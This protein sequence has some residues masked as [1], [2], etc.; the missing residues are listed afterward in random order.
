MK[1]LDVN[2]VIGA[3]ERTAKA[4]CSILLIALPTTAVLASQSLQ[5][6]NVAFTHM[7]CEYLQNPLGIDVIAPRLSWEESSS[8]SSYM[9]SA[10]RIIVSS[11]P[12]AAARGIGDLWD[13][14]KVDSGRSTLIK[15]N[16]ARLSSREHCW[17]S[18]EAW[19]GFGKKSAWSKPAAFSLGLLS[20]QDWSGSWIG[21]DA[22]SPQTDLSA[23]SGAQWIW[24]PDAGQPS[25]AAPIASRY[26]RFTMNI[27]QGKVIKRAQFVGTADNEFTLFVNGRTAG[28]N[29]NWYQVQTI[30][31]TRLLHPGVNELALKADN[32]GDAPNP[33]GLIG[34]LKVDYTDG[35]QTIIQTG[36]GWKSSQTADSG[37]TSSAYD[38]SGWQPALI[39]G[40]NGMQPWG[41]LKTAALSFHPP[42]PARYLR[43]EFTV[44]KKVVSATAYVCGLGFFQLTVNGKPVSDHIFD[45]VLSDYRRA[46]YYVTFD[47]ADLLRGGKN[48]VGVILGNGRYYAPR[49]LD[50]YPAISTS[51]PRLLMQ[52]EITYADGSMQRVVSDGNWQVTSDGPI[53]AN[54][55]YDAEIYDAR[56]A[57][58]GWDR[59]GY[60]PAIDNWSQADIMSSPGGVLCS[61]MM[62][63]MRIT[64]IIHPVGISSPKTG[65][66]IV[67]MGQS[68]Y[69]TVRL[70]AH[71]SRGASVSMQSAYTLLPSGFLKT[72]DNRSALATDI[73]TF[74]GAG[75]ETWNPIFKGQGYRRVQ[76]T[77]FPGKPKTSNFEGLEEHTDCRQVGSFSCSND[78]VNKIHGAMRTGM[79]MFL[80]STPIDPDRDERQAWMG[81]P[82]KDSESEAYN[83]DV[84][85]FYTK[86]MDDVRRS[87]RPDGTIPDVAM[88]WVFGA[89]V[90]WPSVFTIIPDW[91]TGFYADNTLEQ[92]NYDAMKQWVLAMQRLHVRPAG[93]LEA[94]S[95]GDW[96]DAYTIGGKV[97][98]YGETPRDLISTAYQ[99][100][101]IR[102]VQHAAERMSLTEDADTF[103]Q[104][105]DTM[106]DAFLKKFY[107]P[108][109]NSYE[110]GTQCSYVLPLAFGL[111]PEDPAQ[112]AAI[113][114]NLVHDIMVTHNGHLTVGLIG[115]QWL[116][117]VLTAC[118]RSDVS[119]TILTQT[120]RPSWGY[121][122]KRGSTTIWERWDYDTRDPGMNSEAL[123]IQAGNVDAWLYQTLGGINFD[124][125]KPG[126]SHIF[127]RPQMVGDLKWVKCSFDS[128]HGLIIS[129]WTRT[130]QTA[131]MSITIPSNTSATVTTPDGKIRELMS[132]S[133]KLISNVN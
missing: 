63:P 43:R 107:D 87:Q 46:D 60:S 102:I 88:Y 97:S 39:L 105:G 51:S 91:F 62:E 73:Y 84:A 89:G 48:A 13:S 35:S 11:S 20:K 71:A 21:K 68:F 30:D 47:V 123:L 70:N 94:T 106:K 108:S 64:K 129:N 56:M 133:F 7:T 93:T 24:F 34:G 124:S 8:E 75:D 86:W 65:T 69:G 117:Q 81:D 72:A 6:T 109:A 103:K 5:K 83:F 31:T 41:D 9:Q 50:A 121:M 95:Y 57:M 115:N 42:L 3:L 44:S 74:A 96:C 18:V 79:K 125:A 27:A 54:N 37:W 90:E 10:Y 131:T 17:W 92:R 77:G 130:G 101:N 110:S 14:G 32:V 40:P 23:L 53:R 4:I 78:L 49:L 36:A 113:V 114:N 59:P 15:Y 66:Y 98:E 132:G 128:P 61:Q 99:Y 22:Q 122:I 118:G 80:R 67:D 52:L 127:I 28:G 100:N 16:G 116:M 119:W 26:F 25:S 126:F 112:K 12:R 55:E 38:D 29:P 120:T 2:A 58:P 76:V 33:A 85:A 19:D 82:A 104:M 111:L 45:P 1:T